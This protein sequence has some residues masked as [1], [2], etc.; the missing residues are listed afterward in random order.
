MG[1]W[2]NFQ[3]EAEKSSEHKSESFIIR[4]PGRDERRKGPNIRDK[5]VKYPNRISL[6]NEV[7]HRQESNPRAYPSEKQLRLYRRK[8]KQRLQ[9]GQFQHP[10]RTAFAIN[11][12]QV[13]QLLQ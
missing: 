1:E 12:I 13:E 2:S 6:K 7:K 10:Y 11:I 5:E 3:R 9:T 4:V 8:H